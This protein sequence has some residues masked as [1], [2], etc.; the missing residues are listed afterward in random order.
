MVA[1]DKGEVGMIL[2]DIPAGFLRA[3]QR[4]LLLL[5]NPWLA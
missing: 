4:A 1:A 2:H 5:G 3:D